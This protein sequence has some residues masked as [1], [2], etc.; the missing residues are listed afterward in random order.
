M[1]HAGQIEFRNLAADIEI[2]HDALVTV[3]IGPD[4]IAIIGREEEVVQG[5]LDD[6]TSACKQPPLSG[7]RF[8]HTRLVAMHET[9]M[10]R[11]SQWV[12]GNLPDFRS[13]F[14]GQD[15]ALA[16]WS[17]VDGRYARC[18]AISC[19]HIDHLRDR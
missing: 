7:Q 3:P 1:R 16:P 13:I 2:D 8:L 4:E 19:A 17:L 11:A 10:K 9:F 6:N 18:G 15:K 5:R 12:C 14:E